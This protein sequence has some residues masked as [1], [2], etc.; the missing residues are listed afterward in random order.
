VVLLGWSA[1]ELHP[2]P[3]GK[4]VAELNKVARL[5]WLS[6]AILIAIVV[7]ALMMAR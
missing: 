4:V 7:I 3:V 6:I 1:S 5:T 2:K